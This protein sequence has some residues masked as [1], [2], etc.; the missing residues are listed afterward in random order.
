HLRRILCASP[1]YLARAGRPRRPQDLAAHDCIF[2][3]QNA[4]EEAWSFTGPGGG[5]RRRIRLEPR[6]NVND[7]LAAVASAA[8]GR[9]IVRVLSY[10]AE[11][12]LAEGRLL[13]L[14]TGF[15]PAPLPVH[16]VTPL[17]RPMVARLRAFADAAVPTL[18]AN[19]AAIDAAI[20]RK[21]VPTAGGPPRR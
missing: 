4:G 12:E 17:A 5:Q 14:L 16:L 21:A 3:S 1:D 7:A 8:E 15:E 20:D 9:G 2:F 13:R 10:Q 18:R 6:L 11:R 19:L